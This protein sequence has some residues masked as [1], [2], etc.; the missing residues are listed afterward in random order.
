[1]TEL[2]KLMTEDLRLRNNSDHTILV[3]TKTIADFARYFRNPP[4]KMDPEEFP[5]QKPGCPMDPPVRNG[6]HAEVDT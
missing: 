4:D 1:M 3:Y 5:S 6:T 2:R